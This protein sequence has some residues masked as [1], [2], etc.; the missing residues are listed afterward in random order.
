M[1][2]EQFRDDDQGYLSWV[3][4]HAHGYVIN[5]QRSLNPADARTHHAS[6]HTINGQP[7]RGRT[8][9]GPYVKICSTSLSDLGKWALERTGSPIRRC[10]TCQPPGPA[11][12]AHPTGGKGRHR[13]PRRS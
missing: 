6:C 2:T 4:S 13:K 10:G 12:I 8:W 11:T 5:I 1:G 3:A 9:T 7:P